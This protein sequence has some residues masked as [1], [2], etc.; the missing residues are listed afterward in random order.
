MPSCLQNALVIL[1][2]GSIVI[3]TFKMKTLRLEK[4]SLG[5][6][7]VSSDRDP[8]SQ[9]QGFWFKPQYHPR[10]GKTRV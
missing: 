9:V 5:L 2:V 6:G 4:R 1:S 3:P 10:K 8:V 7:C